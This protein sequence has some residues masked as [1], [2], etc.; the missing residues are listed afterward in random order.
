MN[1]TARISQCVQVNFFY[2]L[3][4]IGLRVLCR[5]FILLDIPSQLNLDSLADLGVLAEPLSFL[6][7]LY[8]ILELWFSSK[9]FV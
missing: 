6:F 9:S 4:G 3:N 8:D 5:Y 2:Q 1:L 7:F